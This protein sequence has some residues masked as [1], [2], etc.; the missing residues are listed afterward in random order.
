MLPSNMQLDVIL[1]LIFGRVIPP[2]LGHWSLPLAR[3]W[4]PRHILMRQFAG[5]SVI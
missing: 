2:L 5:R 3:V 4:L 1:V